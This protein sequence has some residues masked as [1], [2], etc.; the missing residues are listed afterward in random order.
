MFATI[1]QFTGRFFEK[2]KLYH[3]DSPQSKDI[4]RY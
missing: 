3:Q 2:V 1:P 4:E